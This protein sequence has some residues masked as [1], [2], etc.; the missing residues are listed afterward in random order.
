[1]RQV[2]SS[3]LAN[4]EPKM[5]RLNDSVT[6]TQLILE[7]ELENQPANVFLQILVSVSFLYSKLFYHV[8][9]LYNNMENILSTNHTKCCR[10][11]YM[12]V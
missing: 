6:V 1:M 7:L 3:P 12:D 4:E 10:K 11:C 2:L 5:I 9:S 8:S